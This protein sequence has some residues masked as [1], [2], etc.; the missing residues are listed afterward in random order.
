MLNYLEKSTHPEIAYAVHQCARFLSCPKQEHG[1]AVKCL[2]RYLLGTKKMGL[3]WT[4]N[5]QREK[6]D[7]EVLT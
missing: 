5:N 1:E 4:V 6:N 3:K 2:C 7:D